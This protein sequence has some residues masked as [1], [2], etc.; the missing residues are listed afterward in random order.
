M[1]NN[2][3]LIVNILLISISFSLAPCILGEVYISEAANTGDDYIEV[4]NGG[5]EECSIA[6][7]QFVIDGVGIVILEW[8]KS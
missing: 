8:F 7:F 2:F 5:S 3:E 4:Y 6:G 1:K